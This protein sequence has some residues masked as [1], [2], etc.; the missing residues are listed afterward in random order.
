M[1]LR[2]LNVANWLEPGTDLADQLKERNRIILEDRD[3]VFQQVPGHDAGVDYFAKKIVENLLEF[4]PDYSLTGS[5]LRNE[6]LNIEVDL[7]SDHPFMQ[8]SKVIAEDLCLMHY[9]D[10]MWRLIDR[11][12]VV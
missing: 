12:S 10:N 6:E 4:H 2:E 5:I 1:G 11:K 7:E 3:Q 9:E 8:L